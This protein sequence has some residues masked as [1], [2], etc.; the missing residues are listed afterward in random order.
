M[1]EFLLNSGD[2]YHSYSFLAGME[3]SKIEIE[4][5]VKGLNKLSAQNKQ[6]SIDINSEFEILGASPTKGSSIIIGSNE[7]FCKPISNLKLR[8]G[9]HES[10]Y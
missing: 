6:G 2:F 8:L 5:A 3:L 10:S 9:L 4:V 1:F 7:L